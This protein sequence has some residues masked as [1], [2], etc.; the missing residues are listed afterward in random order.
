MTGFKSKV[1][2]ENASCQLYE[3]LLLVRAL[4]EKKNMHICLN[5]R[6]IYNWL[7]TWSYYKTAFFTISAY[8]CH[9]FAFKFCFWFSVRHKSVSVLSNKVSF[10]KNIWLLYFRFSLKQ[11]FIDIVWMINIIIKTCSLFSVHVKLSVSEIFFYTDSHLYI[12]TFSP[13]LKSSIFSFLWCGRS[14][15]TV[16]I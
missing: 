4:H 8:T 5:E 7:Q 11:Y 1:Q 13:S 12:D 16:R 10:D 15:K 2:D 14:F 9:V 3:R 6:K